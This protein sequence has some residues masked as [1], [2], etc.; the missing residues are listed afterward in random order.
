MLEDIKGTKYIRDI[1][2]T[3]VKNILYFFEPRV[4]GKHGRKNVKG[5]LKDFFFL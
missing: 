1:L 5:Y 2:S 3:E 4:V